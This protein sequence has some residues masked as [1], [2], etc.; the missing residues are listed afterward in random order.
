MKLMQAIDKAN[1]YIFGGLTQAIGGNSTYCDI[2]DVQE[3][4]LD[5]KDLWDEFEQQEENQMNE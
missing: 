5:H 2:M 4:W 3:R 1:G